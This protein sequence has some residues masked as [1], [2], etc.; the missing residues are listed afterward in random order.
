M[1]TYKVL[2][3]HN[4]YQ[5]GGGEHTV[6]QNESRLL[7]E[8][9]CTVIP[10]T[11]DNKDL[12]TKPWRLVLLPFTTIWSFKTYHEV[13]RLIR[14]H[15]I[16]IVHCHNTFPQISPSVYYAAWKCGVPVVQTV[17]NFRFVCPNGLCFR[18]GHVCE[19]CFTG[20]LGCALKHGC[21]RGSRLQT[22][23]V[24]AMLWLHRKLGTYQRLN[25]IFLTE[26]NQKK[27]LNQIKIAGKSFVK[28]N[29]EI[30]Q[31]T[32]LQTVE[33]N[34][35]VFAGRL[36]SNKGA[37]WLLEVFA[38][39]PEWT[40]VL[41]GKG[42][43]FEKAC[44]MA[45]KYANLQPKGFCTKEKIQKELLTA[46]ALLFPSL[47]Y[48]GFPMSIAESFAV[49]TP[50]LCTDIGNQGALVQENVNGAKYTAGDVGSFEAAV[51]RLQKNRTTLGEGACRTAQSYTP[52][53]NLN[54]LLKIYEELKR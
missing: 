17:H 20:G 6:F 32:R 25:Y 26:F 12:K 35:F 53:A 40:L 7:R 4:Y 24:V 29:F 5:Q 49:G 28:P 44:A 34:K 3:V 30:P 2:M 18:D 11:K 10:Y 9:G 41:F 36:D 14:K 33:K 42:E 16:D 45:Q 54:S 1:Q 21:Y 23:P 47:L 39:H 51:Q 37:D 52:E 22:L 46:C 15:Q 43:Y 50:V 8:N 48:E 19:D 38:A 31:T 27:I 13:K